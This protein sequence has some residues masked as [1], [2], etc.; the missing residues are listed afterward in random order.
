KEGGQAIRPGPARER[1]PRPLGGTLLW[2]RRVVQRA[3]ID[4]PAVVAVALRHS[5]RHAA[6]AAT[7]GTGGR[8]G[9]VVDPAIVVAIALGTH[10]GAPRA[11]AGGV[12]AG[13]AAAGALDRLVL[14]NAGHRDRHR[15][16]GRIDDT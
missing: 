7:A 3:L 10:R 4:R 13:V 12:G 6:R 14:E 16:G 8:E 9:N 15:A 2:Q 1:G 5:D 11:D